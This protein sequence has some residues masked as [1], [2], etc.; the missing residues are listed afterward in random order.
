MFGRSAGLSA[1]L[2]FLVALNLRPS[3]TSVGPLLPR[4]GRDEGLSEGMQ[5]VL[6]AL[7]L[8]AFG[9]FSPIVHRLS[10]R[11]GLE[12]PVLAAL[13]I[14]A[15]AIAVR[16]YGGDGG[17]WVGTA[18]GGCAI[19]V[20]NV[21]VP[22]IVKRDYANHI[23]RATGV[24]S[25]FL[26]VAAAIASAVAV[27]L[28]D[29]LDWRDALAF[30]ALPAAVVAVLWL[31]RARRGAAAPE[32]RASE[33]HVATSVW[34]RPTAWW[35]T[36]FMGLQSTSFYVMVTWLPTIEADA[37][38]S[39]GAT[40]VHL[41]LYQVVGL[42][43]GLAIP[44]LMRPNSQ[45]VAAATASTPMLIAVL[46]LLAAPSLGALWAIVAGFGSGSSL[47]VA[48]SLI[49]LRGR[50]SAETAQLSGM[51]QSLGY[52]LAAGGPV[53]AG[54]LA[55]RTNSWTLSLTALAAVVGL[56][57]LVGL[58]AGRPPVLSV[59]RPREPARSGAR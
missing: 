50:S 35:L 40:G 44:F 32:P 16:S 27:P 15:A 46:G 48:L 12:R 11:H 6:G 13:V 20:G 36:A 18:I 43:A 55:E 24:Y 26:G 21:L 9:L 22:T 10:R 58:R 25:A 3:L 52:L 28:A 23:S 5:G 1:A 47:V 38:I 29:A 17:L 45:V 53:L 54:Y 56:Q 34:R 30:W 59:G 2:V 4:I 51:A 19:A 37:G 31:P 7:P 57:L 41:F 39:E 8:I 33:E 49:S 42:F 14:L